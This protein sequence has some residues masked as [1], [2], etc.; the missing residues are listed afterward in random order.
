[1]NGQSVFFSVRRKSLNYLK[2]DN[3]NTWILDLNIASMPI[4]K[5][6]LDVATSLLSN[7]GTII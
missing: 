4:F 3:K 6:I 2:S 5:S 7:V 1:M